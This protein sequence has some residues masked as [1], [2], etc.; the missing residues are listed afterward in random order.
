MGALSGSSDVFR[1]CDI[2]AMRKFSACQIIVWLAQII[3]LP[4]A[5]TLQ[6]VAFR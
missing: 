3:G 1:L 6:R 2:W 5:Q 4:T